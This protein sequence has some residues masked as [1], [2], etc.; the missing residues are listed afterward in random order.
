ME[1]GNEEDGVDEAIEVDVDFADGAVLVSGN[2]DDEEWG[3]SWKARNEKRN[4]RDW[5][6]SRRLWGDHRAP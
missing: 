6:S 5:F 2:E 4:K 3:C 1:V